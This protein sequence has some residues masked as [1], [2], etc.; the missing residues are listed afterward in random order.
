MGSALP[1]IILVVFLV[2]I[3]VAVVL[4]MKTMKKMNA[5]DGGAVASTKDM[6]TAQAFLPFVDINED[7][8]DLGGFKYRGVIECTSTNYHLKTE[9]EKEIIEQSFRNFL[10]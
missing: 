3:I 1:I 6:S 9:A 4:V 2:M 8:I 5:T 7:V 10:N